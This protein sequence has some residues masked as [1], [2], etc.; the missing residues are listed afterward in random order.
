M[1]LILLL[2]VGIT[3]IHQSIAQDRDY[4]EWYLKTNDSL[5]IYV[6]ELG[7]GKDTIVFVHGGFGA[8]HDY[9]LDAIDGLENKYH[10]VLY[11]QRGSLLSPA[12][13]SKLTFA[14]NVDDLNR[15]VDEMGIKKV[16]LVCHSM[17]TLVGMEFLKLHPEK[18]RDITLIGSVPSISQDMNSIFSERVK[19]QVEFLQTRPEVEALLD[20]YR[21]NA[22][23]TKNEL[24]LTDKEETEQWRIKF[25]SVNIYRMEKWKLMKGGR[26]YYNQQAA[27]M[28]ETVD[29]NYDYRKALNDLG[30]ATIIMGDH[31]FL[32]FD[33]ELYKEQLSDYS[34]VEIR[35]IKDAGHNS[36]TDDPEAFQKELVRALIK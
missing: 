35:V 13:T 4:Q 22:D 12:P 31:D 6:R 28:A 15:L 36:W 23:T 16:S 11:D 1:K 17:G 21:A 29:W 34:N 32:D 26:I 27:V 33:A 5:N 18:V 9:L 2:I 8:N 30:T 19:S 25:A 24:N 10:F 7:T 3:S 20:D 14:K